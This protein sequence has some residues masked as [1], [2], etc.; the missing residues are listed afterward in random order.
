MSKNDLKLLV[1]VPKSPFLW[2]S[3]GPSLSSLLKYMERKPEDV[4]SGAATKVLYTDYKKTNCS[5]YV[6]SISLP[7][8]KFPP[9]NAWI[10]SLDQK[11]TSGFGLLCNIFSR[12]FK[13]FPLFEF[14]V[15]R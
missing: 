8:L 6:Q 14:D 3:A 10:E 1:F 9:H 2:S 13:C 7:R 15:H 11:R 5:W 4:G 12:I